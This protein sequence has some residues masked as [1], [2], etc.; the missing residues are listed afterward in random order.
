MSSKTPKT[1]T[2]KLYYRRATWKNQRTTTL[3]TLLKKSHRKFA[4]VGQRTF[5]T[6]LGGEIRGAVIDIKGP[7]EGVYLQIASYVPGEEASLIDSNRKAKRSNVSAQRA[8]GGN[9]YLDGDV[10]AFVKE[11]HVVLCPSGVREQV[12]ERYIWHILHAMKQAT[13]ANSLEL[14]KVAKADKLEM[15]SKEGVKEIILNSSLY[16][17][18]VL[19]ISEKSEKIS[20]LKHKI[21]EQIKA[22]FAK[23]ENLKEIKEKENLN[24][25]LSIKFDGKEAQKHQK[26]Q[27]FGLVGKERLEQSARRIVGEYESDEIDGFTI[28]TGSDNRITADEIR[29][30][31]SYRIRTLAKSLN[32]TSAWKQLKAYYDRLDKEGVLSQ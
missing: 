1:K 30:S 11:N 8:P 9:E 7:G 20:G 31:N 5:P 24:V 26:D 4:T 12:L 21:A 15:I 3:E 19:D 13:I 16:D 2:K 10:F 28:V 29:V 27:S 22:I 17:A 6:N 23:N 18:S 14:D 25:T 32:R